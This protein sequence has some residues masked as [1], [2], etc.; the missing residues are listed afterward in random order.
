MEVCFQNLHVRSSERE[1]LCSISA[2][3]RPGEILAVMGATGSGKTTLLDSLAHRLSKALEYKGKITYGN[4]R[5]HKNLKRNI[6]FVE[7]DDIVISD[8]TLRESLYYM[9]ELR[10]SDAEYTPAQKASRIEQV[11]SVLRLHKAA[12][13]KVGS[14]GDRGISGGERK[15][16]CI[17][18]EMLVEPNCLLC[19]E[20]TSGLDST[21][22]QLTCE[23]LVDIAKGGKT[24]IITIHQP[25]SAVFHLFDRLLLLDN[26]LVCYFGD[27][28]SATKYFDKTFGLPC[29]QFYNPADFLMDILVHGKLQKKTIQDTLLADFRSDSGAKAKSK[30]TNGKSNSNLNEIDRYANSWTQQVKILLSREMTKATIMSE[31][32]V[33]N[34]IQYIALSLIAALLWLRGGNSNGLYEETD[35]FQRMSLVF[36]VTGTWTFFP[37]FNCLFTFPFDEVVVLKELSLNCYRVSAY[38]TAKSLILVPI[39]FLWTVV[40]LPIVYWLTAMNDNFFVFIQLYMAILF[41]ILALQGVGLAISAGIPQKYIMT[42]CIIFVTF[43]FAFGGLFIPADEVPSWLAWVLYANPLFYGFQLLMRVVLAGTS[44]LTFRCAVPLSDSEFP[45]VCIVANESMIEGHDVLAKFGI[46]LESWI[47]LLALFLFNVLSRGFA[48]FLLRHNWVGKRNQ[49]L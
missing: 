12:D 39:A 26:G 42:F 9:A 34:T 33:P 28:I 14:I 31:I 37:L 6:G 13:T 49:I 5:F 36:W 47:C 46:E 3:A 8:L 7:Q 11:L 19:D 20:P 35:V 48:Y 16:L 22:A 25:S 17:A 27:T 15:R 30:L 40:Y 29:P 23:A 38:Y 2:Y 45:E 21:M 10:L 1:I 41:H 32:T 18:Q 4:E 43:I 24:V 44:P